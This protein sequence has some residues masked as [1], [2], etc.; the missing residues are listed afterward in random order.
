VLLEDGGVLGSSIQRVLDV[1]L[2]VGVLS[3]Q[4]AESTTELGKQLSVGEREPSEDGSVVLLGL[5]EEGGLL[6]LRSDYYAILALI[7]TELCLNR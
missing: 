3:D 2:V 5:A 4:W 6:V 1:L 7:P